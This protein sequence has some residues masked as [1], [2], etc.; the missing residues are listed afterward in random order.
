[1]YNNDLP[2]QIPEAYVTMFSDDTS[3]IVYGDTNEDLETKANQA[4]A[5]VSTWFATLKLTLNESKSNYI[6]Y[7]T[8]KNVNLQI[9]QSKL[10]HIDSG[11]A[12]LLGIKLQPDGKYTE[13]VVALKGKLQNAASKLR[14][15]KHMLPKKLKMMIYRSLLESHIRYALPLWGPTVSLNDVKAIEIIKKKPSEQWMVR[16]TMRM[17]MN[18]FLNTMC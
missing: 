6:T 5:K 17:K 9:K 3:L 16:P 13:H 10:Q 11:S 15:I 8:T 18:F 4:L 2:L 1:M 12:K 7:G 14:Q